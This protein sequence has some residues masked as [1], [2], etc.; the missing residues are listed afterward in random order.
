MPRSL[1]TFTRP[2]MKSNLQRI[3]VSVV[4]NEYQQLKQLS[5]PGI[6]I[7]FLIREAIHDFLINSKN[8]K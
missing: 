8:I 1:G 5:K 3:S 7:G 6:S 4:E 2:I